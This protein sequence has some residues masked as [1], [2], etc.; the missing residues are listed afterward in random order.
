MSDTR[1]RTL[2]Q[3]EGEDAMGAQIERLVKA[4]RVVEFSPIVPATKRRR[5]ECV[6]MNAEGG[7]YREDGAMDESEG[8]G[9]TCADALREAMEDVEL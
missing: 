6:I 8:Q 5:V 7:Y 3:A 2:Q 4:G 1:R 9:E